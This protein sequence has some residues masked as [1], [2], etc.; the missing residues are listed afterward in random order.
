MTNKAQAK[1]ILKL[2]KEILALKGIKKDKG[3]AFSSVTTQYLKNLVKIK[4]LKDKN[5]FNSWFNQDILISKEN[6]LFLQ[7]LLDD[8]EI[9]LS[10][11]NE[12]TLKV[13]FIGA[14]LNKIKFANYDLE[15]NDFYHCPLSFKNN[16]VNFNGFCDFYV[17]NGFDYPDKPYFFIQEYK[18][19]QNGKDPEPQ[20][21]AELIAAVEI[22]KWKTIKGCYII[23][24]TW[25]FVILERFK[26]ND[27]Q[28]FVSKDFLSTKIED[29][30]D[31]FKNLLFV[32]DEIFEFVKGEM[33]V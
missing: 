10:K 26:E 23:G 29:L 11:F 24:A 33:V 31:I 22:N 5:K 9:V 4:K 6:N 3:K 15:I 13:K 2:E 25:N 32:K 17:A 7:E 8:Y 12:D 28:Y 21:V 27:Y 1:K 16:K 20:L 19:S 30:K 14:I 18:P